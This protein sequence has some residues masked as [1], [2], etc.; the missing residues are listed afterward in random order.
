MS[1]AHSAGLLP[2]I[3]A[4]AGN[5]LVSLAKLFGFFITGSGAMFSEAIH[6]LA[7]TANQFL[8]LVGITQS[9]KKASTLHPYGHGR[10]RYIWALI[11]ACGI[12]FLGCGVT[13]YHGVSTL[14]EKHEFT[15]SIWAVI[16]LIISF[17]VESFTLWL[18][19]HEIRQRFPR[20]KWKTINE[21]ADPSTM[22]VVFED[23][24]AVFGVL[25]ALASIGLAKL[26][27]HAYWD[28]IGSIIIGVL[29]GIVAVVLINKNRHYLITKSIPHAMAEE[30]KEIL[31][32]DPAIEKIFDFKSAIFDADRYLIKCEVEF[33]APALM[34]DMDK[35][36]FLANGYADVQ[37]D[38]EEFKK[39]CVDYLDRVPRLVGSR[40]DEIEKKIKD[41]F[42]QIVFIDIEIN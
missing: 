8:L 32:A 26:T 39:F 37:G 18:A 12:F 3:A 16:I 40:I 34:K 28:S 5:I 13:V 29:L 10:E 42:P 4:F 22:A 23:G 36:H 7:D 25:I 11:S 20:A 38:K 9:T 17:V 21:E 24:L 35:Y 27:G 14:L 30:V 6:S 19:Y 41:R 15:F 31:L 2:I 33:N 1:K